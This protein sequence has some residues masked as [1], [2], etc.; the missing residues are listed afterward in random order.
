MVIGACKFLHNDRIEILLNYREEYRRYLKVSRLHA[1]Q[2]A[3]EEALR[4]G[5]E[6]LKF[7]LRISRGIWPIF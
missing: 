6:A 2:F 3:R 7:A 4:A 1:D 5:W